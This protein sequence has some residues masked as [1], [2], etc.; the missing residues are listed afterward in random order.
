[1]TSVSL[2]TSEAV[3]RRARAWRYAG[4]AAACDVVEPWPHGTV[5]RAT[6]YP[7]YY[8]HN[9]LLVDDDEALTVAELIAVA[10]DRLAGLRHRRIEFA[11]AGAGDRL[12]AE[13]ESL[14]W[15]AQRLAWL[16][17]GGV[18]PAPP[19]TPVD[20][21]PVDYDDVHD[22]RLGWHQEESPDLEAVGYLSQGREIALRRAAR[23]FAVS[24]AGRLVG[25]VELVGA[26]DAAEVTS[27]YVLPDRR[28]RGLGSLLIRAAAQ[29]AG[30]VRDLWIC[31]DDEDRAKLLYARLGFRPACAAI[32]FLRRPDGLGPPGSA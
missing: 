15:Q 29:A 13:F 5:L 19:I 16:R 20:V 32:E 31:A 3:E 2:P 4:L 25:F 18:W 11:V 14:G 10:D 17:H 24:D 9:V 30:D 26:G 23:V 27:A 6:G 1:M 28:G 21:Q 22:L 7:D 8:E 12:R